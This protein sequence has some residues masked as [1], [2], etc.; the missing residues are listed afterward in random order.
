VASGRND[1]REERVEVDGFGPWYMKAEVLHVQPPA[2]ILEHMLTV[3]LHLDPCN[4]E[5]GALRVLPG[6]HT[7]GKISEEIPA[8]SVRSWRRRSARSAWEEG[9]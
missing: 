2:A 3:R 4:E 1:C 8:L 6:S 5:N 7:R 9:C